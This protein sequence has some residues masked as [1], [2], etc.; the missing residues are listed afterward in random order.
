MS[1][2]AQ[3]R[4]LR[5]C[6]SAEQS[7]WLLGCWLVTYDAERPLPPPTA[8]RRHGHTAAA[9]ALLRHGVKP[10]AV[11]KQG[12]T[13]VACALLGGHVDAAKLLMG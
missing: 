13:P 11:N 7:F 3:G 2:G 6:C 1:G 5:C 9:E 8:H 12:L 4:P 10:G